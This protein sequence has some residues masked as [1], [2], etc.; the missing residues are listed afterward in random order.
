MAH[1]NQVDF[2]ESVKARFPDF[3]SNALVLDIGSLDLNGN[4]KY[5]F[6][7][8]RYLG[9][10]LM[11]G[12]NVDIVGKGHELAL[13][14]ATFDTII[15]TECFEHD[16]FYEKTLNNAIRMLK[17]GGMFIFTC[18]TTGRPE[19]GTARTTPHDAP[20]I[21]MMGDWADYYKNLTEEDVRTVLD[22][23]KI[24]SFYEFSVNHQTHDLYF[25]GLKKSELTP[26]SY[27]SSGETGY[28][29]M[30]AGSFRTGINKNSGANRMISQNKAKT[31][32]QRALRHDDQ[33]VGDEG[34]VFISSPNEDG[35]LFLYQAGKVTTLDRHPSAGI[36]SNNDIF[37]RGKQPFSLMIYADQVREHMDEQLDDI[38]DVLFFN[39][40]LYVVGTIK[41]QITKFNADG[42]EL[43]SWTFSGQHDS[44]HINCLGLW[45]G[46]VVFSAFGDF[47]ETRSYKGKTAGAGYVEDLESGK[48]LIT[49][50]NQPHSLVQFGDNLLIANS[51]DKEL[52]EY[53]TDGK[54][55]RKKRFNGYVR[56]IT[57]T[58]GHIYVGLSRSREPDK[59]DIKSATI[60][61]IHADS[62]EQIFATLLPSRE[63][64][65]LYSVERS[66][67][68]SSLIARIAQHTAV[69]Y[70]SE[71]KSVRQWLS[72]R[73]DHFAHVVRALRDLDESLC[74]KHFDAQWYSAQYP[75]LA[76]TGVMPEDH[77]FA[78]GG[79]E[80][81][82][83]PASDP[84][85]FA[86]RVLSEY[87]QVAANNLAAL[88]QR[89]SGIE[90][91][92]S[93][94][95]LDLTRRLNELLL[96]NAELTQSVAD[97]RALAKQEFDALLESLQ[98]KS[99][100]NL[101]A[102]S[103]REREYALTL[104][105][106]HVRHEL[107][108]REL[109]EQHASREQHLLDQVMQSRSELQQILNRLYDAEK[110]LGIK[111]L[112][113]Q[114]LHERNAAELAYDFRQREDVLHGQLAMHAG[115]AQTLAA[116]LAEAER[117][118]AATIERLDMHAVEMQALVE[119]HAEADRTY[120]A[121][122][123]RLEQ[124]AEANEQ[125]FADRMHA[126]EAA[127]E[128]KLS[129]QAA[130]LLSCESTLHEWKTA[131]ERSVQI[132]CM[133]DDTRTIAARRIREICRRVNSLRRWRSATSLRQLKATIEEA[134][135]LLDTSFVDPQHR[136]AIESSESLLP[137]SKT[138]AGVHT[139]F[140]T[141]AMIKVSNQVDSRRVAAS[142][143]ELLSET[144]EAFVGCAYRT[145]LR[146]E[147]DVEGFGYYIQRLR[148][149][150]EKSEIIAQLALS[151]EGHA[152]NVDLPGL[153]SLLRTHWW[154]NLPIVGNLLR[155]NSGE[156]DQMLRQ[157]VA[158]LHTLE[159]RMDSQF[160]G[161]GS[162][163]RSLA[164]P[165]DEP[166]A[167]SPPKF[168]LIASTPEPI[169]GPIF[170]MR[171]ASGASI[172][173]L[174]V[175]H[176]LYIA[177][178]IQTSLAKADITAKII[179]ERPEQGYD[180]VPHIVICP[181]IFEQLPGFYV[182]FQMEQSVSSRW[183][184]PEYFRTLENS[185]AILDY[186]IDN[187]AYLLEKGLSR[188][189]IYHLPI[190]YISNYRPDLDNVD[191]DYDILFYGDVNNDRRRHFIDEIE[192]HYRVKVI[193][194][195]FGPELQE[196]IARAKLV[197]NVHYYAGALLE[198]TRVY[199]CLSL[200]KLVISESSS[201]IKRHSELTDLVD[202]VEID[203]V[204][205]MISRIDYWLNNNALRHQKIEA[206]KQILESQ[207]NR[208]DYFLYRFLLATDNIN[209]DR[210]W[211][212]IGHT[213]KLP[214]NRLCLT[215]PEDV[216]RGADFMA[217][218]HYNFLMFPGLR[219]TQGWIGCAMSY[220]FMIM[221]ARQQN[222]RSIT[223]CEDDVDFP[224]DFASQWQTIERY[225]DNAMSSWD[226]FSGLL[227]NLSE[228]VTVLDA[229][230]TNG[231][232]YVTVDK[233]ISTVFNRYNGNIFN[234]I[235]DWDP[236][237]RDVH[238]NTID[239]YLE[240]R[241]S[242]KVLTTAPF[243]V[244]HKEDHTSTIWGFQNTQYT[245]LIAASKALLSQK[246]IEF[247]LQNRRSRIK[248]AVNTLL[249]RA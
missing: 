89:T 45:N 38:H 25:A 32:Q 47:A 182:A 171:P 213:I 224:E 1:Q 162:S 207:P 217:D 150:V 21:Q 41:N 173:I 230:S 36:C 149:G 53:S 99:D 95:E 104:Q 88:D 68:V 74:R 8:C 192:K 52:R 183:F 4:N 128:H 157:I 73:D 201:D 80:E 37:Y 238:T 98:E 59:D 163:I 223:I 93:A 15:S 190:G 181:Q 169:S 14:D 219:H 156:Q 202:F 131:Y 233:L 236:Q 108:L 134:S 12:D 86:S 24:F 174:T 42:L 203:D 239:R 175:K 97:A 225:L 84:Y 200:N 188:R 151:K 146:R 110:K 226:I 61:K 44:R 2:C 35:G 210:F 165:D 109:Q 248:G 209:F 102:S 229:K 63:I 30:K 26:A 130:Q 56:G 123:A 241:K 234:I 237:N 159:A 135:S 187:V 178:A 60:V 167:V 126:I 54:L 96:E 121:T 49:G 212:L 115:K 144:D 6:D 249:K 119:K 147:P 28:S 142:V 69:Q 67:I 31:D 65:T 10:D 197:I 199:E 206:N 82:R 180:D 117:A 64:Y 246:L 216:V 191:Q 196:E 58:G 17:P 20:F 240:S 23:D 189:Q 141:Q 3:F 79:A 208:F 194:N 164:I 34:G 114:Q 77:F 170:N 138:T 235:A 81:G 153:Q 231:Q 113:Q 133:A 51:G 78:G 101:H 105:E 55:V 19:H 166:V 70:D 204:S 232:Q 155:R 27:V 215:L 122:I 11:P 125:A 75:S 214:G 120:A 136:L 195:L 112:E 100:A 198:T 179:F 129:E 193:N 220:K 137:A 177:H 242:L 244:G 218:N 85:L 18:A 227:A 228:E 132:I 143:N 106:N 148:N 57:T 124:R 161:I 154:R 92:A 107:K 7:G 222:L 29:P 152:R 66:S 62:W 72:E 116:Q 127:A 140:A 39:N 243:L 46:R 139:H 22:L 160:A 186:S 103:A 168:E 76:I 185:Y 221:L 145:L 43:K 111:L 16:R 245:D 247:R 83:L 91:A 184:T 33:P 48:R 158:H 205:A 40:H 94:R 87:R 211:S 118:H 90:R 176:C 71:L 5:L 9:L 172:V 50:L 13:P